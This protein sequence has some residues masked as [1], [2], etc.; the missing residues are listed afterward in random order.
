MASS[1]GSAAEGETKIIV[2]TGGLDEGQRK[3]IERLLA[4]Y[5]DLTE[6]RTSC[7]PMTT[8]GVE[9]TIDTG[10]HA[11]IRLPRRRQAQSEQAVVAENVKAMLKDGV[12]EEG[13]SA[14][15]FQL[16]SSRKGR[17]DT[18]LHQLQSVERGNKEGRLPTASHR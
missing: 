11:P 5:P 1:D 3:L 2:N 6:V 16:Y 9:H 7:P 14:R 17:A 10:L 8:T 15:G 13:N 18:L 12:I 4:S